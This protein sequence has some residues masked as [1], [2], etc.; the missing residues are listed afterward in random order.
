MEKFY[1][2]PCPTFS[3]PSSALTSTCIDSLLV[4]S[5]RTQTAPAPKASGALASPGAQPLLLVHGH[6]DPPGVTAASELLCPPVL[7][8]ARRA[9]GVGLTGSAERQGPRRTAPGLP[10]AT[11]R[12]P[13]ET[14]TA[15]R[16]SAPDSGAARVRRAGSRADLPAP[17][18]STTSAPPSA[19]SWDPARK[20][21]PFP[22]SG[23]PLRSRALGRRRGPAQQHLGCSRP[24]RHPSR[25][26]ENFPGS[27]RGL[28]AQGTPPS[29]RRRVPSLGSGFSARRRARKPS[30]SPLLRISRRSS[31]PPPPQGVLG[32]RA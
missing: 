23:P 4:P 29:A 17:R 16:A 15:S 5:W 10:G 31:T 9:E 21:R 14:H 27:R 3:R 20:G 12:S 32:E 26:L 2:Q 7:D 8:T 6:E 28:R 24:G 30:D 13:W 25:R 11:L 1:R 18:G 22:A 19:L